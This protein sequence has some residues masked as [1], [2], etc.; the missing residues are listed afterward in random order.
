MMIYLDPEVINYV[1]IHEYS[2][3]GTVQKGFG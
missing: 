3:L 1:F 2:E